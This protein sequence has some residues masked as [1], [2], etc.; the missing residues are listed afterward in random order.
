MTRSAAVSDLIEARRKR[1]EKQK[2]FD[3]RAAAL[4]RARK[5]SELRAA[6]VD[7]LLT[8]ETAYAEKLAD[9]YIKGGERPV[10]KP[11]KDRYQLE[12]EIRESDAAADLLESQLAASNDELE[13]AKVVEARAIDGVLS[14]HGSETLAKAKLV[15]AELHKLLP[16]LNVMSDWRV[17]VDGL[18]QFVNATN[19]GCKL[20]PASA[21][22][23]SASATLRAWK[24][25]LA[26][27]PVA[28][29]SAEEGAALEAAE[30][31]AQAARDAA[32]REEEQKY[33]AE[34][35]ALRKE[36]Q[37]KYDEERGG[38]DVTVF[39]RPGTDYSAPVT[40]FLTRD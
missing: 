26:N 7:E 24:I 37:R 40:D 28:P 4:D 15:L 30:D 27:D 13:A 11:T 16:V 39:R 10:Y 19:S 1:I 6:E 31:A 38:R 9:H 14:E 21:S 2:L 22:I 20:N 36:A 12:R 3:S 8:A 18:Y 33:Q 5:F 35:E 32:E 17:D 25:S 34:R 29:L 23:K